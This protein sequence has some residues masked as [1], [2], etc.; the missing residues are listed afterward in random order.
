MIL[1]CMVTFSS[2]PHTVCILNSY[3]VQLAELQHR[4]QQ[5]RVGPALGERVR[6]L[7]RGVTPLDLQIL[8]VDVGGSS[9]STNPDHCSL[10]LQSCGGLDCVTEAPQVHHCGWQLAKAEVLSQ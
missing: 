9:Q 1:I 3:N 10:V 2:P 5:V 7:A 6:H 8:Q 4:P